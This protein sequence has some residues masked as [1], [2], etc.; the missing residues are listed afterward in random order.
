MIMRQVPSSIAVTIYNQVCTFIKTHKLQV[1]IFVIAFVVRFVYLIDYSG[2]PFFQG[3]LADAYFHE[4]WAMNILHGDIFSLKVDGVFYK[5]P[6]YPYFMAFVYFISGNSGFALMLIQVV[7]D[8]VSCVFIFLIGRTYFKDT[9]AFIGSMMYTFYFPSVFFSAEMEIPALAIFLT[10]V[11]FYLVSIDKQKSYLVISSV[12]FGFSSLALPVNLLLLPLYVLISLKNR[13]VKPAL[14]FIA[15]TLLTIFPCTL[16]NIVTG[17]HPTLVSANGGLN[18]YIGNNGNY[19]DTVY[20]QPGYAF[21]EFYDEPRRV[22]GAESFVERDAY[23]Y[24]KAMAFILANPV[25]EAALLF[26]KLVLYFSDYEIYRNTDTYYAKDASIYRYVPFFPA[27]FILATGLVGMFLAIYKRKSIRPIFLCILLAL[28][29]IVFFVTDRYRLPSMCI[30]AI[31]SGF[32]VACIWDSLAKR[33]WLT[34]ITTVAAVVSLVVLSGLNMFVVKN[35]EYRPHFNLGIIYEQKMEYH[36]ALEEY[37]RS[38]VLI[39]QAKPYDSR[40]K[41][42]AYTRMGN[43]YMKMNR[44]EDAEKSLYEA[45]EINP[46]SYPA[47]SY[48]GTLYEKKKQNDKAVEMYKK[49]IEIDP[50]DAVSMYNLGL[51][52]FN[53]NAFDEAIVWFEKAIDVYPRHS[54]AHGNL[55]YIYGTREK[56]DLMEEH[57]LDAIRYDQN[58]TPVRYNLAMLY[59]NT[60]R[61]GEAIAQYEKITRIAPHESDNACNSLG[62]IYAQKN[63]LRRAIGYW[64]KALEINPDHENA[65]YNLRKAMEIMGL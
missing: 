29:C 33:S 61:T 45:I 6:L 20:L 4:E 22:D 18:F 24:K 39:K 62:V 26:K 10:L 17:G 11:S 34:G 8:S 9:A 50:L 57:A 19:D 38:L 44:L 41:S 37:L 64:K 5:A 40:T 63:D 59:A 58:N 13:G 60:G 12:L 53:N 3:R 23:W 52:Y 47:Y 27:S 2:S 36:R 15:V 16:R 21:E 35:P 31:F 7:M 30:W 25:E 49:A 32:C 1:I 43:V 28:P 56:Y 51:L 55:A 42:E 65:R 48:L 54:G 46:Q 14:L